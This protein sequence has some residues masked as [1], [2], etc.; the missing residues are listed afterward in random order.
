MHII[1]DPMS[2]GH[3][4]DHFLSFHKRNLVKQHSL[5][6]INS[7]IILLQLVYGRVCVRERED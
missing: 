2:L 4:G 3:D 6:K 5:N 7:S 1:P